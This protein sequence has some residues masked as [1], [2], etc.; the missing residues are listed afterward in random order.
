ME[1]DCKL[2]PRKSPVADKRCDTEVPSVINFCRSGE[3]INELS[4]S[5]GTNHDQNLSNIMLKSEPVDVNCESTVSSSSISVIS[6]GHDDLTMTPQCT[7]K[8]PHD[9][10]A[11]DLDQLRVPDEDHLTSDGCLISHQNDNMP[12]K[13]QSVCQSVDTCD[14]LPGTM[15]ANKP[16]DFKPRTD[17]M[18]YQDYLPNLSNFLKQKYPLKLQQDMINA[19][20]WEMIAISGNQ[21]RQDPNNDTRTASQGYYY[22]DV[23]CLEQRHPLSNK[24]GTVNTSTHDY[25]M[26]ESSPPRDVTDQSS[27]CIIQNNPAC[28][29]GQIT[30]EPKDQSPEATT[31]YFT[32]EET[33]SQLHCNNG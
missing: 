3:V 15:L 24:T 13:S 16:S 20:R 23:H 4:S 1:E 29:C 21:Y 25:V 6:T 30:P 17:C 5:P 33:E 28:V 19:L 12:S 26:T 8:V 9:V 2:V 18:Q 31:D 11:E 32:A 7:V 10:K 14:I 22:P 27:C